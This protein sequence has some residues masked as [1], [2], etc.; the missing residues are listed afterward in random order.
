MKLFICCR[1]IEKEF[2]T[3][4]VND[5]LNVSKNSIA[6]L[7]QFEH[8]D[9]W[10]SLVQSKFKESDFIMFLV[11]AETFKSEQI[12]W[13]YAKAKDLNK[14]I[15][16]IRLSSATEESILFCQGFQVFKNAYD[17]FDFLKEV[18]KNDR[19]LKIE[20]YKLMVSSTEK[21]T[22]SRSKVNSL[23][24]TITSTILSISFIVIKNYE[25]RI[26]SIGA[27]I[28]LTLLAFTTTFF[29]SK[30]VVSYGK[31]NTG[32]FK[33]IDRLEKELRTNMFEEEWKILT[34]EIRYQSNTKTETEVITAFRIFIIGLLIVEVFYL[35]YSVSLNY[36]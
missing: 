2:A 19:L 36:C 8:S 12:L 34:N 14:Q 16:G 20:Q 13:E 18:Y 27:T 32:K 21:V 1:N 24:F 9:N 35:I 3:Q 28:I 4:I 7:Q 25:F 15:V 22:D 10:K 30:L 31:L 26:V 5:L 6:I 17:S 29:W 23:F 33:L 11:G